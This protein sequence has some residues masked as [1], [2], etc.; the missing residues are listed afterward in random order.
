M[1]W[2]HTVVALVLFSLALYALVNAFALHLADVNAALS[3]IPTLTGPGMLLAWY[4]IGVLVLTIAKIVK[5]KSHPGC[6]VHG[7]K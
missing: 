3:G 7:S 5:W 6:P 1:S 4:F 2:G